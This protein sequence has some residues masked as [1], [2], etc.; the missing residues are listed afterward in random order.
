MTALP[1]TLFTALASLYYSPEILALIR[2]QIAPG[3][4]LALLDVP[5]GTGT[6]TDI[7]L[8][9]AYIGIDIDPVRVEAAKAARGTVG[10]F[11][12]G[13]AA[14]LDF[15]DNSLDRILA[16]GLFHHV[17]DET[18]RRIFAEF[19][20]TLKPQGHLVVFEAIWPRNRL[21]IFGII[22]RRLDEGKHVRVPEAYQAL[23]TRHF[24]TRFT[25]YPSRLGLD[26]LL[27]TLV[28]KKA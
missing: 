3:Q 15:P 16:A 23:F 4:A 28:S 8:P 21:N 13:D 5:C 24:D 17:D 22:M 19:A 11:R 1:T 25:A 27:Q 9:C 18:A 12:V 20:R 2:S 26:Y 6:L 7:C 14:D 10:E